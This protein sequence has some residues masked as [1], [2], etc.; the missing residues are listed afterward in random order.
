MAANN[1]PPADGQ[2]NNKYILYMDI[3]KYQ[4]NIHYF[5]FNHIRQYY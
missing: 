3:Y 5:L 1:L 2:L 4:L